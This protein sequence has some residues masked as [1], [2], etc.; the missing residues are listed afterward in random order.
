MKTY[1][2]CALLAVGLAR[3]VAAPLPT[4]ACRALVFDSSSSSLKVLSGSGALLWSVQ[5]A[6]APELPAA[7]SR[8]AS[9]VAFVSNAAPPQLVVAAPGKR[10]AAAANATAEMAS[11]NALEWLPSDRLKARR[12]GGSSSSFTFH[13]LTGWSTT[14]QLTSDGPPSFASD[15]TR[16][17]EGGAPI[18]AEEF[19]LTSGDTTVGAFDHSSALSQP[20]SS[21]SQAVI[22]VGA[23]VAVPGAPGVQVKVS[24][25][26][27]G[28]AQLELVDSATGVTKVSASSGTELVYP[29]QSAIFVFRTDDVQSGGV[30]ESFIEVGGGLL[31]FRSVISLDSGLIGVLLNSEN[32][33]GNYFEIWQKSGAGY[34]KR[35]RTAMPRAG[36]VKR[37]GLSQPS[38]L[39][40]QDQGGFYEVPY[41]ISYSGTTVTGASFGTMVPRPSTLAGQSVLEWNCN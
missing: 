26:T 31:K 8:D 36:E 37:L 3:A 21:F 41:T 19:L 29:T 35:S 14:P 16:L 15:C 7:L 23:T 34:V 5:A 40:V 4:S 38:V 25:V 24:S 12:D 17:V 33:D 28:R 32:Q 1:L 22:G 18:C 9:K 11:I 39:T 10:I 2:A 30:T 6:I 20:R 27:S 13:A